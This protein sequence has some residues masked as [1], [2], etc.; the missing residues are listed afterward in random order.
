MRARD[1]GALAAVRA[2]SGDARWAWQVRVEDAGLSRV[3]VQVRRPAATVAWEQEAI[4]DCCVAPA[5]TVEASPTAPAA[6]PPVSFTAAAAPG[7]R[8]WEYRF[9]LRGPTTAGQ[10]RLMRN[11]AADPTWTWSP[12]TGQVGLYRLKTRVRQ[13]GSGFAYESEVLV[14]F[15]VAP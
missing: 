2:Y 6:R 15:V 1:G 11:Y 3:K 13:V 4:L 5:L 9:S 8:A 10:R 7:D 12:P 14:P